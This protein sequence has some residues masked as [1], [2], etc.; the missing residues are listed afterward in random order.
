MTRKEL[1]E[2]CLTMPFSYEDYP[3]DDVANPGAWTVMRHQ[4]N[5][6][7]FAMIYERNEKLCINLKCDQRTRRTRAERFEIVRWFYA[8]FQLRFRRALCGEN[9]DL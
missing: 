8:Q 6:K 9:S 5:K 7:S 1:I 2:Y 3:F 4:V